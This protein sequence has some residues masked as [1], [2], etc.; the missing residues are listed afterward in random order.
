MQKLLEYLQE[1]YCGHTYVLR[2]YD[3]N[4]SLITFHPFVLEIIFYENNK[5]L[6]L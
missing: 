1:A 6:L 5:I 2:M 4:A 3:R